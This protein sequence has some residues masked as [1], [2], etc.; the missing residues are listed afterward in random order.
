MIPF[1]THLSLNNKNKKVERIPDNLVKVNISCNHMCYT[2]CYI[3]SLDKQKDGNWKFS[4]QCSISYDDVSIINLEHCH[5]EDTDIKV[6]FE[7][8][9][10]KDDKD[11][12]SLEF[13]RDYKFCKKLDS[14]EVCDETTYDYSFSYSD[15]THDNADVQPDKEIIQFFYKL[16]DKYSENSKAELNKQ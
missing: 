7:I 13:V 2:Y 9:K 1:F 12:T 3:F 8:L 5:I 10:K 6:L 16:A 14:I 11:K 4:A 15:G